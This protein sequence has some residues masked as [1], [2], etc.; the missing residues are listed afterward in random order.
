MANEGQHQQ[1]NNPNWVKTWKG[2]EPSVSN[3]LEPLLNAL[4]AKPGENVLDV[5][6]GGGLTTL[7][8]AQQV[9]PDGSAVGFD[10][11]EPLL[12]L[13]SSRAK[14]AEI[15]NAHF[16]HGDAQVEDAP[17]GPFDAATSRLGVM[18]F[19]DPPAAFANIRRQLRP[20]GRLVFLCFQAAADNPWYPGPALAKYGPPPPPSDYLPISP[21]A[22]GEQLRTNKILESAGFDDI[23]F[24]PLVTEWDGR[25]DLGA[26]AGLI[27]QLRLSD[28][29]AEQANKDVLTYLEGLATDGRDRVPRKYWIV[30]AKNP[31]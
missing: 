25:L 14:E 16:V 30:S 6:C 23:H 28:A 5:G 7:S 26:G 3:V 19:A 8:I 10:I 18:F 12:E 31:G 22:L 24:H 20:G 2:L 4:A 29:H 1:W 17:G 15:S 27:K 9:G 11:S 21:F 13:A